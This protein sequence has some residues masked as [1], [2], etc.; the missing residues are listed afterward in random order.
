MPSPARCEV[1]KSDSDSL[2]SGFLRHVFVQASFHVVPSRDVTDDGR[3][4]LF[5]FFFCMG[6]AISAL[7][8]AQETRRIGAGTV[9]INGSVSIPTM[10][11]VRW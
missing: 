10:S 6:L 2:R 5:F 8:L 11:S 7:L 9:A 4:L 1:D 3:D